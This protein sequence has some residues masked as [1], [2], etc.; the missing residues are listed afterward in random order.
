MFKNRDEEKEKPS[1]KCVTRHN[2]HIL[3]GAANVECGAYSFNHL[4]NVVAGEISKFGRPIIQNKEFGN[5]FS[6]HNLLTELPIES[7][8]MESI[9]LK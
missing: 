7:T 9:L 3:M 2:T 8:R 5:S 4:F 1:M 6:S